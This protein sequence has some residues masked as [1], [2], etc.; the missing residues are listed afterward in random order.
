MQA[1][2]KG[3]RLHIGL[4]GRRNVGKSSLLNAFTREQVSIVSDQAGTTTDPVEK[5]MELLP[6]GPVTFIDTAG[7]DDEGALGGLRISKTFQMIE[8]TD[9]AVIITEAGCWGEFENR[10]ADE[11]KFRSIP[12]IVVT[13]KTDLYP[14]KQLKITTDGCE[15]WPVIATAVRYGQGMTELRQALIDCA[16]D[17]YIN[18]PSIIGDLV[19]PGALVVLV[20][21]IDKEASKGRLILPSGAD[22][23]GFAGQ[24][25]RGRS[26]RG[27]GVDLGARQSQT[28]AGDGDHRQSG[29]S[30]SGRRYAA[31]D[32]NDLLFHPFRP[33]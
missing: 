12:I 19:E 14:D 18:K 33:L 26:G 7:I 22:P 32:Q 16:P 11:F 24:W 15:N 20:V 29:F 27:G 13:N 30:K 4:F 2:P 23:A 6:L 25:R 17:D 8:R 1:T 5:S 9:V 21:P 28:A 31:L 10:L 3:L